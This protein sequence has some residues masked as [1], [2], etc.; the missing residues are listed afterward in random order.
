MSVPRW[1]LMAL[2][3]ASALLGLAQGP[4]VGAGGTLREEEKGTYLG[5]LFAPVPE[6]LYAQLAALPRGGGVLLTHILPDSPAARA[7]LRRNDILLRYGRTPIRDCEHFVRLIRED[8]PGRKV[9]LTLLR[10]GRE[11]TTEATL[12]EGPVLRIAA[13]ARGAHEALPPSRPGAAAPSV[14]VA[15]TPLEGNQMKVIIAYY[16]SDTGQRRTLTCQ[17]AA[18]E[19]DTEI[20]K[21]P[22]RERGLVRAALERIR[23]LNVKKN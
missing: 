6:A 3:L 11:L 23:S 9:S 16:Q 12:E 8:R 13:A 10:G 20:G 18:A 2:Y 19:I 21:L 14:S 22:P 17:G 15:V 1:P 7:D 5:A 4:A